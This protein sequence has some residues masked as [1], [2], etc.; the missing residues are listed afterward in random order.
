ML[1]KFRYSEKWN[2]MY[3]MRIDIKYFLTMLEL[4]VKALNINNIAYFSPIDELK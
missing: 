2:E 4:V 3:K 1:L